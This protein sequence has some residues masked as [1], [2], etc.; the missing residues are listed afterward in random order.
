MRREGERKPMFFCKFQKKPFFDGA[1]R[2]ALCYNAL[3]LIWKRGTHMKRALSLVLALLL[4]LSCAACSGQ[5]APQPA[6]EPAQQTEPAV[7]PSSSEPQPQSEPE[8]AK[9][10]VWHY[11]LTTQTA[12][13]RCVLDDNDSTVLATTSYEYPVLSAESDGGAGQE[14]PE[15]VRRVVDAFNSG[16]QSYLSGLT[17]AGELGE[18]AKQQYLETDPEYR[19]YFTAYYGATE[20]CY[21][22]Q[23]DELLEIQL[24]ESYYWGG[25]HGVESFENLH[26]DLGTGSF[27][28][29]ADLTDDAPRLHDLIAETIIEDIFDRGEENWYFENFAQSIRER[30]IYNVSLDAE[31]FNVIF[32]EYEIAAYASGLPE[33]TVPYAIIC[34]Y[35][36]ERGLRLLDPS[37]E[38]RILGDYYDALAMWYWFEGGAPLD[39][40]D[41]RMGAY[42]TGYGDGE[43]PYQ[44]IDDP[45]VTSLDALRSWLGTRFSAELIEQ[46]LSASQ[47]LFQEFDG[48]LYAA[49]VGRGADMTVES[50]DFTVELNADQSGG[51]ILADIHRQDYDEQKADWVSTGVVDQVEFPFTLGET[52]AIFSAFPTIW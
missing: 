38:T 5:S 48:V 23:T 45:E 4:A 19:T 8:P 50:V 28:E 29:L 36:N 31:G 3:E 9:E 25:A 16:V 32:D 11:T 15:A 52:G 30:K 14:P 22:R 12:A 18:T 42:T 24:F 47:S 17:S 7:Q 46:R 41:T 6:K 1:N 40:N 27:F 49:A 13:D 39:Y 33:F 20:V 34:R 2:Q 43:M 51:R 37:L 21:T 35:L 10:A 26:F 44:R